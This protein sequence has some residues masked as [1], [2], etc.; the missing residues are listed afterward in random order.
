M[1][2]IPE[3]V[4]MALTLRITEEETREL[5]EISKFLNVGTGSGTIKKMISLFLPKM[6]EL[7]DAKNKVADQQRLIEYIKMEYQ[8]IEESQERIERAKSKISDLLGC[9]GS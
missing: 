7:K 9:H 2:T 3:G 5:E 6:K 4:T 1:N 8:D